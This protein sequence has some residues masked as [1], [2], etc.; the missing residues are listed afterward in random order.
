MFKPA[1]DQNFRVTY[2]QASRLRPHNLFLDIVAA[3]L[4]PPVNFYAVQA[5]GVPSTG[6]TSPI[7]ARGIQFP[8]HALSLAPGQL[9]ANAVLFWD[10]LLDLLAQLAPELAPIVGFLQMPGA[11]PRIR[12]SARSSGG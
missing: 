12:R 11:I 2:N 1:E 6:Y 5:R 3:T 10:G 9:P 8:L 7:G 4:P